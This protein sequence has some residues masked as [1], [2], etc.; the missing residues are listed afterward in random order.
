MCSNSSNTPENVS[1][2]FKEEAH[3]GQQVPTCPQAPQKNNGKHAL[4]VL[5]LF[6]CISL[7]N[8]GYVS[9]HSSANI[10]FVCQIVYVFVPCGNSFFLLAEIHFHFN[11]N[12][13]KPL[14]APNGQFGPKKKP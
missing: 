13:L 10:A 6:I 2:T 3:K 11:I 4:C 12:D 9:G 14:W 7:R 5:I 1:A 8:L